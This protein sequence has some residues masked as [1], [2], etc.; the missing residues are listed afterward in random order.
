MEKNYIQKI[1]ARTPEETKRLYDLSEMALEW[2]VDGI[3]SKHEGEL[4]QS[5][6]FIAIAYGFNTM[7]EYA[8][9]MSLCDKLMINYGLDPEKIEGMHEY[10][11]GIVS[12]ALNLAGVVTKTLYPE[13]KTVDRLGTQI[14]KLFK[15]EI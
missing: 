4:E 14:N 1:L 10:G 2:L 13:N 8:E 9:G 5:L 15:E 3:K 11:L 12:W 7:Q 6:D